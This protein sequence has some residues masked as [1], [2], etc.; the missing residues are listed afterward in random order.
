[1]EREEGLLQTALARIR[2][3]QEKGRDDVRLNKGE[4]AALERHKKRME[5]EARKQEHRRRK[6][7]EQRFSIPLTQFETRRAP[8]APAEDDLPIHPSP[9]TF[10]DVQSRDVMPPAGYF[11]PPNASR[12][13]QRSST[14]SS[15]RPPAR[16]LGERGSSPFQYAY[17]GARLASDSRPTSSRPPEDG[18]GPQPNMSPVSSTSSMSRSKAG[19]D[20]FQFQTEGPRAQAVVARRNVSGSTDGRRTPAVPQ[21]ARVTRSR[22]PPPEEGS[23]DSSSE[24]ST[25]ESTSDGT[26]NGGQILQPPPPP[27][28]PQTRR[29][30]REAIVVEETRE[31]ARETSRGK[32][33]SNLSPSK[34]KPVGG[35][36]KKK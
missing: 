12:T 28:P 6:D 21:T 8:M 23:N 5:K 14:S 19:V 34:R 10:A 4:M 7:K 18:W 15:Q 29:G 17:A 27:P 30:R 11:P 1:M 25:E 13:R 32:K 24:E 20:P 16:I 22:A 9:G 33:S 36:K 35:R 26:G 3:A 2:R 31:P